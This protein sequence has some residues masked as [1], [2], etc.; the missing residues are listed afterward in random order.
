MQKP[1]L[2]DLCAEIRYWHRQRNFAMAQRKRANLS[3]G[4]LLRTALGWSLAIPVAERNR[5]VDTCRTGIAA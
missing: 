4:S 3:L 2:D 1:E 5:I